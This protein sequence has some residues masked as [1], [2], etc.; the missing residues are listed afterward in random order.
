MK[1]S[2]DEVPLR[3]H[4]SRQWGRASD[5]K[6]PVLKKGHLHHHERHF[7]PVLL[8]RLTVR[9][10][11]VIKLSRANFYWHIT[12]TNWTKVRVQWRQL[13]VF[14]ATGCCVDYRR[15]DRVLEDL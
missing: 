15:S 9:Y 11:Q 4:L 2:E 13:Y 14:D 3:N 12:C 1:K 5:E 10:Q 7:V 8:L 6:I